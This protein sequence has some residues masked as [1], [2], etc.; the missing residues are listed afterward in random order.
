VLHCLLFSSLVAPLPGCWVHNNTHFDTTEMRALA[1]LL[2]M[3]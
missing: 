3:L 1:L 2:V